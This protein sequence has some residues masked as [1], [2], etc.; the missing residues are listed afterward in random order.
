MR[1]HILL[2]PLSR[3]HHQTLRLARQLQHES[4]IDTLACA[5][6]AQQ[7]NLLDHFIEEERFFADLTDSLCDLRVPRLLQQMYDEHVALRERLAVL[8]VDSPTA[9]VR[10]YQDLGRLLAE[11]VAFE[12]RQLFPALQQCCLDDSNTS[13]KVHHA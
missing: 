1:R 9:P 10:D 4:D 7:T 13:D 12:E 6:K 8:A 3:D 11:H 5:V 2:Q